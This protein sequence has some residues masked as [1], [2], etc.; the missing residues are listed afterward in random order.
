M[1]KISIYTQ[2]QLKVTKFITEVINIFQI[3]LKAFIN[4]IDNRQHFHASNI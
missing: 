1:V 4:E 2:L 3:N